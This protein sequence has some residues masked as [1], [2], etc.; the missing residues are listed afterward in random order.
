MYLLQQ[1]F[2]SDDKAYREGDIRLVGGS[3]NWEGR[4][5]IYWSGTWG[6]ISDSFWT[7]TDAS[8]VCRQLRHSNYGIYS[9]YY[10]E[11]NSYM[12]LRVFLAIIYS[13]DPLPFSC[14]HEKGVSISC[15]N[16][17]GEGS[18]PILIRSVTCVGSEANI[19][20]C[21]YLNNTIITNHQQDVGVQCQQGS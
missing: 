12:F 10:S 2:V 6:T 15:C 16:V 21:N 4:V 5:E 19:T 17:F 8:V 20:H 3:Y 7:A 18:G 11:S 9:Y 14:I 13:V 1:L